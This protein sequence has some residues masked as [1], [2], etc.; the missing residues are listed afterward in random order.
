MIFDT[1]VSQNASK[2]DPEGSLGT[3]L[4]RIGPPWCQ[5]SQKTLKQ[6]KTRFGA[7]FGSR[8]WTLFGTPRLSPTR[9]AIFCEFY[10]TRTEAQNRLPKSPVLK[11]VKAPIECHFGP[12]PDLGSEA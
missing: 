6:K 9:G 2:K 8:F 10:A 5:D 4:D 3:H 7:T 1:F 11:G 12:P